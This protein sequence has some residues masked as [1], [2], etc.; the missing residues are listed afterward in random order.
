MDVVEP[1]QI[2]ML[3]GQFGIPKIE[4]HVSAGNTVQLVQFTGGDSMH[5]VEHISE[6]PRIVPAPRDDVIMIGKH[7]PRF[8][9]P[10]VTL[11]ERE[12]QSFQ[13][14]TLC[15]RI[16]QVLF[17]QRAGGD[18]IY[19]ILGQPMNRRMWPILRR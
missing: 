14:I 7:R 13:Q 5:I 11:G 16:K 18:E 12:E 19:G 1:R 15:V 4:P 8:Q 2:A 9:L 10:T 3:D 6:I 17:V